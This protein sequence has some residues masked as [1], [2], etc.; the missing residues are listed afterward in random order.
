MS[1][2]KAKDYDHTDGS[3]VFKRKS[4]NSQ[5]NRKKMTK[6]L[7]WVLYVLAFLVIAVFS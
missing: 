5:K 7:Q 1:I 6:I 2:R 4:F 3:E